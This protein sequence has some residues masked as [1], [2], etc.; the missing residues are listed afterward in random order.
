MNRLPSNFCFKPW[1]ELFSHFNTYGPCCV[2]YKLF[3]GDIKKYSQSIELKQL[4]KDF[5]AGKKPS[6]CSA[7]WEAE[8]QGISSVRQLDNT[9][10]SKNL[11]T[12][13]ISLSN[14]CNFKCRM[15]NP[16]DSS[17]WAL[18]TKACDILDWH[19]IPTTT[20]LST[21]DWIIDVAKKQHLHLRVMGGEPLIT[22]EFVYLLKQINKYNLYNNIYLILT[23]NLSVLSFRGMNYLKYFEKFP[24]LDIYAS[25]DGVGKVGEYIRHGFKFNKFDQNLKIANKFIKHLSVTIQLYNIF[26]MPNIFAYADKHD[27]NVN[28]NYLV[29]PTFLRIENLNSEDKKAVLEHYKQNNFINYELESALNTTRTLNQ[30]TQFLKYTKDLDLLWS[31]DLLHSIPELKI[32]V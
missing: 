23:T 24:K 21:V 10:K 19:D 16:E 18:D 32:L 7:C 5:L 2:N 28:F 26:D 1:V 17:A 31:K 8:A 14:K 6:S 25:F 13:S 4:K 29:N 27:L 20:E 3:K 30:K 11:E 9:I 15:C 22:D 12:I